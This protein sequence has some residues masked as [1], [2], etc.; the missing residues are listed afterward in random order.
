MQK[1]GLSAEQLHGAVTAAAGMTSGHWAAGA[2]TVDGVTH[3]TSSRL[4]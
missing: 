1:S 4:L 3:K 2:V